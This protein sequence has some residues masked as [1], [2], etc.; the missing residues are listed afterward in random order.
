MDAALGWFGDIIRALIRFI[1][2][3]ILIRSTHAGI[4]FRYGCEILPILHDNGMMIPIFKFHRGLPY[5]KLIKT[6]LHV[7]WPLVTEYEVVPIKRQTTNLQVQYLSTSDLK[8]IGVSGIL[9]Y[10]IRDATK[11]LTEC[12]DY[13]DTI[14]DLALAA[15]KEVVIQHDLKY[16]QESGKEMDIELT[17]TLREQLRPFGVRTIR[18][19]L[20][21]FSQCKMLGVWGIG[22]F[23]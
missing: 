12:Y 5:F 16:I 7:Y 18:V 2:Q 13:E 10:E 17:K 21:D 11:L 8:T 3:I 15:V 14:R 1:P 19:T 22:S 6:G 4:K 9:V 23:N 20:S